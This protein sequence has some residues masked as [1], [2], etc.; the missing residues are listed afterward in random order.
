MRHGT[1]AEALNAGFNEKQA[2]M[3]ARL[4][5]DTRDETIEEIEKR[6]P[7][8]SN[9]FRFSRAM[10]VYSCDLAIA[11]TA[12]IVGFGLTVQSWPALIGLGIFTRFFFHVLGSAFAYDDAKKC[13]RHS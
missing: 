3:L 11:L 2:A 8:P 5:A 1:Y 13:R 9:T 6:K 7:S 10:I 12:W 4:G